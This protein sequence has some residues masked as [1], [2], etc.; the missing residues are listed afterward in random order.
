MKD[1]IVVAAAAGL[2][3][4]TLVLGPPIG[5]G[6]RLWVLTELAALA[7]VL[8]RRWP[9]AALAAEVVLIVVT[10]IVAPVGTNEAPLAAAV[11]LCAVSY[12]HGWSVVAAGWAATTGATLFSV[13]N[14]GGLLT[15]PGG[16]LRMGSIA[17]AVAAPV[18]FGRYLAGVRQAAVVAEERARDAEE[19][20]QAETA[21][22]LL[23]ERARI[24]GD[25]HDMVAHHVS[26]I[27]MRAGSAQYAAARATEPGPALDE[28]AGALRAIH[29]SAREALV[30]LRGL[31][32][33]LRDADA[34]EPA[35][36]AD[37]ERMIADAVERSRT[38]G[39][40]V[41]VDF[42]ARAA[43]APLALRVTAARVVQEAL[44]NAL[45]HAG[46]GTAVDTT[47][48]VDDD[49]LRIEVVNAGPTGPRPALPTS[50]HGLTG[51]RKRVELHGGTLAAGPT[52]AG[53][54]SL[55][56]TL[57]AAVRAS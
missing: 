55:R 12:R 54:W 51:M 50:G 11:A 36:L 35:S 16:V 2:G 52:G 46:P 30:D 28:A 44:T 18:A 40:G 57:P 15:G 37:P 32:R 21:A 9:L 41:R 25:L 29:G 39:L 10:D 27:A 3:S 47:V 5:P 14:T 34:A 8:V 1:A 23:A 49:R 53:G 42:D 17:L 20:R 45:K 6:S 24:A 19:R 4:M 43:A 56:V 48:A 13:G 33:V 7:L 31:L 26:A 38:A 22:A